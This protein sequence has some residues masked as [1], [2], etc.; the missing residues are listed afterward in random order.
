VTVWLPIAIY[1]VMTLIVPVVNGAPTDRAYREHAI[2]IL[3]VSA[4][5]LIIGR[6]YRLCAAVDRHVPPRS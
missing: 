4:F 2:M 3:S 5:V 1:I 6:I